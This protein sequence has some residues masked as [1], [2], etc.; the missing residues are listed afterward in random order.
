VPTDTPA[1]R[2]A[3]VAAGVVVAA[4][5]VVVGALNIGSF[6]DPASLGNGSDRYTSAGSNFRWE[7]W[8]Q[9]WQGFGDEPLAGTGAGS[10]DVTNARYRDSY[11]DDTTEPHNLPLQFL[12]ETG[13]VG[14]ALLLAAAGVLLRSAGRRR[15]H[16]LALSLLLPAFLAHSLIDVDWDFAAVAVPAFVA[17]GALAGRAERRRVSAPGL[18]VAAGAAAFLFGVLLL[19]WLGARWAEDAL[20]SA[21]ADAVRLADRAEA[22]DPLLVEPLW[23]KALAADDSRRSLAY[24][25]AA[26]R[27]QPENPQTWRLAGEYAFSIRCYRS[28]YEYLV[29]YTALDPQARPSSGGD[30]YNRARDEVNAG[31]NRC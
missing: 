23:A 5:V 24:Y 29:V 13:V 25:D 11:L 10:F 3:L 12:S 9:A 2:R 27:R 28:A 15:E 18:L 7:W 1:L 17:A 8:Q 21:P 19:P 20:A 26:V 31:N 16:E 14:L 4:V 6:T 22:V 30:D